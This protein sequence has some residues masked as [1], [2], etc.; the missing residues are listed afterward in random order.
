MQDIRQVS[1]QESIAVLVFGALDGLCCWPPPSAPSSGYPGGEGDDG[2]TAF[3]HFVPWW[4]LQALLLCKKD[5]MFVARLDRYVCQGA[6]RTR[7]RA[8]A[9][10]TLER[11]IINFWNRRCQQVSP[12][13]I[14]SRETPSW[15]GQSSG[16][17]STAAAK[18]RAIQGRSPL[19]ASPYYIRAEH[20]AAN[21]GRKVE[22][23]ERARVA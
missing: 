9:S 7:H 11:S 15:D 8:A 22:A 13:R 12:P 18:V 16:A 1:R 17:N 4:R 5:C 6:P 10:W 19:A 2:P 3:V 23:S 21:T 20:A 14:K